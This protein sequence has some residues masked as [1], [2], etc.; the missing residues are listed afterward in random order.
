LELGEEDL[1]IDHTNVILEITVRVGVEGLS[2][3]TLFAELHRTYEK[4]Y[5]LFVFVRLI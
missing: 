4:Y 2:Q 1:V 5:I 3:W